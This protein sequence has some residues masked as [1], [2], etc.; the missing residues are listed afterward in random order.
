MLQGKVIALPCFFCLLNGCFCWV[1]YLLV[2]LAKSI[3]LRYMPSVRAIRGATTVNQDEPDQIQK[4]C[5]ELMEELVEK[6]DLDFREIVTVI[7]TMTPDLHSMNA[8]GAIRRAMDWDKVAFFTSQEA[9]IEEMLPRCIR[10]LIQYNTDKAQ[11]DMKHVYLNDAVKLRPDW[12][13]D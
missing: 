7:V 3:I 13:K 6:N 4:A 9:D 10:V 2:G 8:S 1:S 11:I 12:V 5:K